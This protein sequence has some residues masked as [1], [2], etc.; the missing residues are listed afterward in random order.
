MILLITLLSTG[1]NRD[2][3]FSDDDVPNGQ[4]QQPEPVVKPRV[5]ILGERHSGVPWLEHTLDLCFPDATVASSFQRDGYFFQDEPADKHVSVVV[6]VTLNP[7]DWVQVMRTHPQF[8]PNHVDMDDWREF[9]EKPWTMERP[10]R[11]FEMQDET[12]HV[13]QQ[14][15]RYNQVV[16]CVKSL[17]DDPSSNPIYEL[18]Q[19]SGEPFES[20]L[21]LRAAKLRNHVQ[22]VGDWVP[23]L[24]VVKY[25]DL[26]ESTK[27]DSGQSVPGVF[28]TL[29]QLASDLNL[30]WSCKIRKAP[31][32]NSSVKITQELVRFMNQHVDWRAE[33]L[34]GYTQW[35]EDNIP[36]HDN[37][38]LTTTSPTATPSNYPTVLLT[39]APSATPS[40]TPTVMNQPPTESPSD[41]P[42]GTLSVA[43]SAGNGNASVTTAVPSLHPSASPSKVDTSSLSP[44][45]GSNV[46]AAPTLLTSAPT[47]VD[48]NTNADQQNQEKDDEAVD[49]DNDDGEEDEEDDNDD[50]A[51][52]DDTVADNDDDAING[53]DSADNQSSSSPT[54]SPTMIQPS[55][56]PSLMTTQAPSAQEQTNSTASSSEGEEV[57]QDAGTKDQAAG[58]DNTKKKKKKKKKHSQTSSEGSGGGMGATTDAEKGGT[59]EA[60]NDEN[61]RGEGD[62]DR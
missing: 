15:F 46:T 48:N 5:V 33:Q 13:C 36:Y 49:D 39:A 34:V 24:R 62:Q 16:S 45:A 41:A 21:Q 19:D 14:G 23:A 50:D 43:P 31:A 8:M 52:D 32:V 38:G 61:G 27:D 51:V 10:E 54:P 58:S 29:Q 47:T 22:Q 9:L 4:N 44:A 53:N 20:I 30:G 1:R 28:E 59:N 42:S 57:A 55:S 25:E 7:Y 17:Q 12:G 3:G 35:D 18:Q 11:D 26:M 2:E 6:V 37:D 56:T 60:V 40:G